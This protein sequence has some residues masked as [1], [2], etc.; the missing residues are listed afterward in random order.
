MV[1]KEI[2][3]L[4]LITFGLS[5]LFL[6]TLFDS[7]DVNKLSR[8]DGIILILFFSIFVFYLITVLTNK[9][10]KD[11]AS[12]KPKHKVPM[13]I[14]MIVLGLGGVIVGSELVVSNIATLAESIGISQKIISVT[15]ISIG[16][17][18]PE[19]VKE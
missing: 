9:K 15:I 19:N 4:T 12:V 18:L 3:I 5:V 13:S 17:S 1:T 10:D 2:P 7:S 11:D 16:T 8:A 14:L 6:D